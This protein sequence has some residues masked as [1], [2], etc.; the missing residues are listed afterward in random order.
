MLQ[1]ALIGFALITHNFGVVEVT[2][3]MICV[4]EEGRVKVWLN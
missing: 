2:D 3:R 4:N 1:E